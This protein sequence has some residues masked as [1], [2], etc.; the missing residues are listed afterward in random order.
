M[1]VGEIIR[2]IEGPQARVACMDDRRA[3]ECPQQ[4][5]CVFLPM[6]RRAA[7][8]ASG[9]CA[10]VS[11]QNLLREENALNDGAFFCCCS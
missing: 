1:S 9:I 4:E 3:S 2:F 8:A 5:R 10:R 11:F 6:W 7:E